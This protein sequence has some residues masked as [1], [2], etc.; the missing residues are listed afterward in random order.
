MVSISSQPSRT[1]SV[2]VKICGITNSEDA[3]MAIEAGADALGFVFWDR[4]PR[5]IIPA[6]AA[7]IIRRIPPLM[8][9]VG[10]FVDPDEA[11]VLQAIAAGV[12]LLQFHGDEPPEFCA[13]FGLMTL[14]A[15]RI[16]D[17]TSLAALADYPAQ[18]LLL[19]AF[20]PDAPGGTGARFNWELAIKAK[21]FGKPIFLACGLTPETVADAIRT[22][23]PYG[24]DVSSG[25]EAAPGRKDAG[26]VRAFLQ[27]ARAA[28]RS[29]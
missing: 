12:N 25:V 9:K 14:K 17:E 28:A 19:D 1:E 26:K 15:F 8:M 16:K 18:A 6:R 29:G 4:S 2:M 10:V 7:E 21:E 3:A 11:L 24:V 13:Q 23:R 27:A 22:V 5:A 20:S